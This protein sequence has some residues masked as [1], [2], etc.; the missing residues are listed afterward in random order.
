MDI[1]ETYELAYNMA[2]CKISNQKWEEAESYLKKAL[3]IIPFYY[4]KY[5]TGY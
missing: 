3:G 1:I 5:L 4:E 2:C